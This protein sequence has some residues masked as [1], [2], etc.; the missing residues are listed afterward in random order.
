MRARLA[1][2][3]EGAQTSQPRATP[4]ELQEKRPSP[5][6]AVPVVS[7][8]QGW[9]CSCTLPKVLPWAGLSA[10]L[11]PSISRAALKV[12]QASPLC[13]CRRRLLSV[14]PSLRHR[15]SFS[16]TRVLLAHYFA[17]RRRAVQID[18]LHK[19]RSI[20]LTPRTGN[21]ALR[22]DPSNQSARPAT[23]IALSIF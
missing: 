15:A 4:W 21:D 23:P 13:P 10:G 14:S 22:L 7:P 18:E 19:R 9:V 16:R 1:G 8:I 5:E 11:W 20:S 17:G 2:S 6:R 3:T 12:H